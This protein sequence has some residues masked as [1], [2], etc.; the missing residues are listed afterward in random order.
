MIIPCLLQHIGCL[1]M[2]C[3]ALNSKVITKLNTIFLHNVAD[4]TTVESHVA[5]FGFLFFYCFLLWGKGG[6]ERTE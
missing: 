3:S 5:V 4:Y 2:C 6:G 1:C